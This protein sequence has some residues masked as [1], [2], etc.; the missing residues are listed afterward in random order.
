MKQWNDLSPQARV[1]Y[2]SRAEADDALAER[3]SGDPP[4][5]GDD[6]LR[7]QRTKARSTGV[8]AALAKVEAMRAHPAWSAGAKLMR[9]ETGL[10]GELA[11]A[12]LK[13]AAGVVGRVSG[14]Y[15]FDFTCFPNRIIL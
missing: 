13:E 7:L 10:A 5:I 8:R 9:Y 14:N 2:E 15:N 1:Q 11:E 6:A 12:A 4:A 3:Q